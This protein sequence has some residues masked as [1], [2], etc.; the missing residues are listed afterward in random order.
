MSAPDPAAGGTGRRRGRQADTPD[1]RRHRHQA[2]RAPQRAGSAWRPTASANTEDTEVHHRPPAAGITASHSRVCARPDKLPADTGDGRG[3]LRRPSCTVI[4]SQHGTI[5]SA[6]SPS[7]TSPTSPEH[8]QNLIRTSSE[9]EQHQNI[10]RASTECSTEPN[11]KVTDSPRRRIPSQ[12]PL[13]VRHHKIVPKAHGVSVFPP[14]LSPH[15]LSTH[16]Y[17]DAQGHTLTLTHQ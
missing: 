6:T 12:I 14:P 4:V 16:A 11:A 3:Q 13:T 7:P 10:N 9:S 5:S 17:R 1:N 8:H 15:A 2:A